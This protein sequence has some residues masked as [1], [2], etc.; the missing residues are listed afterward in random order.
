MGNVLYFLNGFEEYLNA[1]GIETEDS[2]HFVSFESLNS[3]DFIIFQMK[4]PEVRQ[5]FQIFDA[6]NPV[7][8]KLQTS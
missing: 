3:V 7:K 6:T 8:V 5:A 1:V 4:L 2:Q